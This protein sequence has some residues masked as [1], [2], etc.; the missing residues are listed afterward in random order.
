MLTQGR[1]KELL[2]YDP[3]TGVFIRK[4]AASNRVHVGAI[5][6][7]IS[8]GGYVYICVD[9]H[10]YRAHR[11]A[12]LYTYGTFPPDKLDHEDRNRSNNCISNLRPATQKQN[13]ENKGH[14]VNNTSGFRG[15]SWHKATSKWSAQIKHNYNRIH[16]GLFD[17]AEDASAAYE[18]AANELFTHYKKVA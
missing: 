1:L 3:E 11:L 5:A 2:S 8:G 15:V 12:W 14:S 7:T 6:G 9:G 10:S 4:I 17:T 16:L 18:A 13:C